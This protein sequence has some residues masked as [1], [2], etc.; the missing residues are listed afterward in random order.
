MGMAVLVEQTVAGVAV[1]RIVVVVVAASPCWQLKVAPRTQVVWL[2]CPLQ[3]FVAA[4]VLERR[5]V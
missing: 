5:R 2:G 4:S 3:S 1:E